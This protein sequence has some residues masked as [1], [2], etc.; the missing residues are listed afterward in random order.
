VTTYK[1][2]RNLSACVEKRGELG[3]MFGCSLG[4]EG[5]GE[6]GEGRGGMGKKKE[7]QRKRVSAE[8]A[9]TGFYRWNHRWKL[10][11]GH[12]TDGSVTSL[13]GYPGLNPSIFL[14]IKSFEKIYV[15][16]SLQ[17]SK[18]GFST[19]GETVGIYRWNNSV[20]IYRPSRRWNIFVGKY[21]QSLRRN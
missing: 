17:L 16:T 13:N 18:K 3:W 11:I 10:S 9:Y 14:S 6:R 5:R 12:S 15:I 8:S 1:S 21:Q 7:K 19:V 20:G 4:G 2:I